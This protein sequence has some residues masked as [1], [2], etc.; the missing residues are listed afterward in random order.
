MVIGAAHIDVSSPKPGI[1][2]LNVVF[3]NPSTPRQS[4]F[5]DPAEV[6]TDWVAAI[7]GNQAGVKTTGGQ[8][9][10]DQTTGAWTLLD[11]AGK[12]LISQG[13]IPTLQADPKSGHRQVALDIPI[14]PGRPFRAYGSGNGGSPGL[15]RESGDSSLDNGVAII[16]Y[17]WASAGYS[18]FG[19][20]GDDDMPAKWRTDPKHAVISWSF[21][22]Q[23]ASLYLM[24]AK[25]LREAARKYALLSG[26][27]HVPPEWTFGYLQSRWGWVDKAYADHTLDTFRRESLP[28]DAFIFDFESYTTT[29][30]YTLPPAGVPGFPDF[31]W[32]PLLFPSPAAN[33]AV[34]NARGIQVVPIRK[35][36]IGDAATLLMIHAHKWVRPTG[37]NGER[38]N[39]FDARDLDFENPQVRTW[40]AGRLRQMIED[41]VAGWWNDE[42][43]TFYTKYYYWNQAEFDALAQF[44]PGAR[45]WSINR[46]FQPGMQRFGVAAWTGDIDATWQVLA[47]TPAT[48]LDWSLAGMPYS[49]CDIGGFKNLQLP[50]RSYRQDP[51]PPEMMARWMEAGVFFPVMR[52]HSTRDLLPHFPWLYGADAE[53][54]IRKALDLRYRLIPYYYSLA[55]QARETGLPI[56]R[57]LVMEF[58]DDPKTF[59]LTDQWLMGSNLMAAPILA[60]GGKRQVYFPD[61]MLTLSG[62]QSFKQGQQVEVTAA[63]DEIPVYVRPGTILPLGPI[64]QSTAQLPGGPLEVRIYPGRDATFALVEDDGI[65]CDYLHGAIRTTTFAWN[66]ASRTLSWTQSGPYTGKNVFTKI[67]AVLLRPDGKK[68]QPADLSSTGSL[69]FGTIP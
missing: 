20:T 9:L 34:L 65:S 13:S 60:P 56:M 1:F 49:A 68:E 59:N 53:N 25:D 69:T 11:G 41:G 10:V 36:R 19:I 66:D 6:K 31:S 48:L 47:N 2:R 39:G 43:E 5:L 51:T 67:R 35:P 15:L 40:Y 44:R 42:G 38:A 21:P 54:A 57:P 17:Y 37:A 24:P 12:V 22:G 64:V 28:V 14:P 30:D 4:I 52:S 58:P 33:I 61:T 27:P 26:P 23:S 16:P 55:H 29:P 3:G 8:L 7:H 32:N 46:A 63:L 50:N 62:T 45:P 18:A